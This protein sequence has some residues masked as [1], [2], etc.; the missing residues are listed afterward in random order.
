MP[1]IRTKSEPWEPIQGDLRGLLPD[2]REAYGSPDTF[3]PGSTV[4]GRS[5]MTLEGQQAGL[6]M[7]RGGISQGA[8]MDEYSQGI[9]RGDRLDGSTNPAL[10]GLLNRGQADISRRFKQVAFPGS[11]QFGNQ[12]AGSASELRNE[13]NAYRG[14]GDALSN[15]YS[16]V[17]GRNYW[18]ERGFQQQMPQFM[19]QYGANN[20]ANIGM[21]SML[22]GQADQYSQRLVD[23]QRQRHD[24][25]QYELRNRLMGRQ[26][27]LMQLGGAGGTQTQKVPGQGFG[28]AQIAGT[29]LGGLGMMF[30]PMGGMLGSLAGNQLGQLA[31]GGGGGG[32]FQGVQ[33]VGQSWGQMQPFTGWA[34]A[35]Y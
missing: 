7:I 29:V 31:G 21:G 10:M 15:N 20:R 26:G 18:N 32:G 28:G 23:D 13:R 17:M 35:G 1:T 27:A 22:G 8:M 12:R 33:G 11:S 9:M 16:A 2:I 19:A 4:G 6:G 14:L 34:G 5:A 24:F 25:R 3:F 30:G